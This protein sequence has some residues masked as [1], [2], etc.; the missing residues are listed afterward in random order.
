[1][2][3]HQSGAGQVDLP[4]IQQGQSAANQPSGRI[5]HSDGEDRVGNKVGH[6]KQVALAEQNEGE[7]HQNH[8]CAAVAGAPERCR[9]D[10]VDTAQH[11]KWG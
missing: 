3:V 9:I 5:A 11:V 2:I 8:R 7:K 4:V 1:M 6:Y 10:L